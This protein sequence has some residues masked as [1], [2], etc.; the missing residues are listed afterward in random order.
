MINDHNMRT[1]WEWEYGE[2]FWPTT[3]GQGVPFGFWSREKSAKAEAYFLLILTP[4]NQGNGT[5]GTGMTQ[6]VNKG[7]H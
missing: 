5:I 7:T 1:E 4:H 2:K 6:I 3:I